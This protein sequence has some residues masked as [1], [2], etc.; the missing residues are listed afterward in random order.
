MDDRLEVGPG[1][2]NET[3]RGHGWGTRAQEASDTLRIALIA[4]GVVL[5]IAS[6]PL[7]FMSGIMGMMMGSA[8]GS[9]GFMG[10]L[11]L[12]VLAAGTVALVVG[13]RLR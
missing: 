12:L 7:L 13:V 1:G 4:L 6:L 2:V 11:S 9:T 3:P 10:V 5:L 8:G